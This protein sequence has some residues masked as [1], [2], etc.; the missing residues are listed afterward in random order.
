MHGSAPTD[1]RGPDPHGEREGDLLDTAAAGPAAIRG[2]LL[3]AAGYLAAAVVSLISVSLIIRQ[4]GVVDFGH[5]VTVVSLVTLAATLSDAG[6]AT[7]GIREYAVRPPESRDR[8][9]ANLLGL[10]CV[11]TVLG[12]AGAALFALVA[13]YEDRLVVGTLVGG[14]G[15]VLTVLQ[16][17]YAVPLTAMLR[18]GTVT[19]LD[20]ARQVL[21]TAITVPV[22]FAGGTLLAFLAVPIP[23][24]IAIL[25]LTLRQIPDS[26]PLRPRLDI[27]ECRA[28][29]R[30]I[31]PI[32]AAVAVG[33]IYFRMSLIL[34]SLISSE[35]QTGYFATAYRVL[36]VV[37]LLPGLIVGAAFPLLAR[38]ARDDESRLNYALQRLSEAM[39]I[40]GVWVAMSVVLGAAFAIEVLAGGSADPAVAVLQL[41]GIAI[42]L[43]FVANVWSFGLL[44]LARYRAVLAITSTGVL[45]VTVLT[46]ALEPSLHAQGAALAIVAGD[47][48]QALLAFVVLRRS[49]ANS[50]FPVALTV[51]VGSACA[52]GF[53]V[54]LIPGLSSFTR[55][56]VAT[57]V[58][59]GALLAVGAI[60]EELAQAFRE[61]FS[62]RARTAA[63][64]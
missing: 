27:D 13:G 4:L 38:A 9:M 22:V 15:I 62:R 60:P 25:I 32:A 24:G 50:R 5:Y 7:I 58:Y 52:L 47:S 39:I 42:A 40:V 45:T 8:L 44:S 63:G 17:T 28:M 61:R 57:V 56:I 26:M 2:S 19:G 16:G 31:V 37:I 46:L 11:L 49:V 36:E 29:L 21:F 6:L 23:V 14:A 3:R 18:L 35:E 48:V 51:R 41:Q 1:G 12:V 43:S 34:M 53:A 20:F 33:A 10:R 55:T 59:F 30:T 54:L 64:S